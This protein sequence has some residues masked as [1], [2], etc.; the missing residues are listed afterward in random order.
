LQKLNLKTKKKQK[1]SKSSAE[2]SFELYK[3]GKSLDEIAKERGF[4]NSTIAGH[5]AKFIS[6]GE[7]NITD[8]LKEEDVKIIEA[9]FQK[10]ESE[11]LSEII[12]ELNNKYSYQDLRYVKNHMI[13]KQKLNS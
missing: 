10:A 6:S 5:L 8:F 12:Q 9:A 1:T 3:S 13:Y 2:Q 11:N 7:L 4:V